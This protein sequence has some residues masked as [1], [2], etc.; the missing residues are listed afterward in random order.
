MAEKLV[1]RLKTTSL[2]KGMMDS[3]YE[4]L[5][6]AQS[7]GRK[8]VWTCGPVPFELFRVLDIA[9]QHGESY[10]AY[11]AARK[12][13]IELKDAAE[14][15]GF[16]PDGCSYWR[17]IGGLALLNQRGEEVRKDM[18]LPMPDFV[19]ATNPCQTMGLWGDSLGR[20][21]KVP[22]FII[23][24]PPP[25]DYTEKEFE[26]N[27]RYIIN[28]YK[29]LIAFLEEQ[30]GK[31]FDYDKLKEIVERVKKGAVLRRKSM[32]LCASR[33]SP[34][35]FFDCLISLGP[36]HV[37]RGTPEAIAY[38]EKLVEEVEERVAKGTGAVPNEKYRLYWDHLPIWFNVG[39]FSEFLATCG[40]VLI[41][42][43]YTHGMFYYEADMIDTERPLWSISA[44]LVHIGRNMDARYR[45]KKIKQLV[46]ELHLD[47][48]IMHCSRTCRP[49]NLGQED[50]IYWAERN[51]GIPGIKI[52]GD[53]TDPSYYSDAQ[54]RTRIQAFIETMEARKN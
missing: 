27:T 28:Q 17:T 49:M 24:V 26:H 39:S 53:P 25:L 37:W 31:K 5:R 46:E 43:I 21:C 10:G 7:Q 19:V 45:T 16:S 22:T 3:Y 9:F 36:S 54:T 34:Q 50:I 35:T 2:V 1:N 8:L 33:P 6:Q 30:T 44:E 47:G 32:D 38:Y 4:D 42:G 40:A 51:L 48:L 13:N 29:E 23:D 11:A 15:E 14:T 18:Y 20:L 52:D 12:G 41:C